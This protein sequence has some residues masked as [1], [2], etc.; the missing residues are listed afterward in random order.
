MTNHEKIIYLHI[1][2]CKKHFQSGVT[3]QDRL[4]GPVIQKFDFRFRATMYK[5][6]A[7]RVKSILVVT[8]FLIF[9]GSSKKIFSSNKI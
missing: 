5:A 7:Y 1:N 2:W 8:S 4:Y 3:D 9:R 6:D